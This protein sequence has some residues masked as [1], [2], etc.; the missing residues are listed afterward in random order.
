MASNIDVNKVMEEVEIFKTEYPEY[1][2]ETISDYLEVCDDFTVAE[3]NLF[4]RKLGY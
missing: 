2:D 4:I 3:K 1:N